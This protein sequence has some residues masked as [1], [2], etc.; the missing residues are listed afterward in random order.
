MSPTSKTPDLMEKP[1]QTGEGSGELPAGTD[2]SVQTDLNHIGPAG[3]SFD[4]DV[5]EVVS[6]QPA[7]GPHDLG[8]KAAA[9]QED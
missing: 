6:G 7:G 2:P 5:G 9:E 1:P 3:T 4:P 8:R